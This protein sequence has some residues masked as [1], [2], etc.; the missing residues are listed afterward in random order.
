MLQNTFC[1]QTSNE[2]WVSVRA[3]A[4]TSH[5]KHSLDIV[6]RSSLVNRRWEKYPPRYG[7]LQHIFSANKS[8]FQSCPSCVGTEIRLTK[9]VFFNTTKICISKKFRI[10]KSFEFPPDTCFFF[11]F[12][13][14][15]LN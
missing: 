5:H 3:R 10:E 2:V 7:T 1:R 8:N 9:Q 4:T 6:L 12:V 14:Y 11:C 13:R 15:L